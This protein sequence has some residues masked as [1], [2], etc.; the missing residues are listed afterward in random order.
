[1]RHLVL[2]LALLVGAQPALAER[3]R[4]DMVA[5]ADR[6]E[7][8]KKKIRALRAYTLTEELGLD[9]ATSAKLFPVLAKWDDVTD[10][11][12]V[13]RVDLTK[14]LAATDARTDPK[15]INRLIDDAVA[16]QKAFWDLEDK[17]LV[18]LRKILTPAQ[19]AQ[20]VLVLPAFERRIQNQLRKAIQNRGRG[21]ALPDDDDDDADDLSDPA[22]RRGN[23]R[24]GDRRGGVR[25]GGDLEG[26][27]FD[28][29]RGGGSQRAPRR[30]PTPE[31]PRNAK[32]PCDAFSTLH[33][34]LE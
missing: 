14:Q 3:R 2:L 11:L 1:M 19:T 27:P 21:R 17:R 30:T 31:P 32:Q 24:G 20:I 34:C 10:K 23:R 6:R 29:R 4:N 9:E 25:T 7:T 16:N 26:N 13:T 12:L 22:D 5:P 33:G 15:T 8:V 18:E 28:D